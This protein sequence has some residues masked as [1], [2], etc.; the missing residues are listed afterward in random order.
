MPSP[1]M[2]SPTAP[3]PARAAADAGMEAAGAGS[4]AAKVAATAM[5]LGLNWTRGERGRGH[6]TCDARAEFNIHVQI[7]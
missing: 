2:P 1:T 5:H 3:R 6:Q 4:A 7:P